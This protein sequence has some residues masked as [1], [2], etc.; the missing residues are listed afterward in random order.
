MCGLV[1]IAGDLSH[2]HEKVM[3]QLFLLDYFRGLDSTGFAAVRNGGEVHIAKGA[4]DPITLF[5]DRR[6]I[7]ALSGFNSKIFLGHNR[8]ATRGVV[9]NFN[10][11]P[12]QSGHITC[13][14]NGTLDYSSASYLEDMLGEKFNVDSQALVAAIAAFGVQE[15][16][17]SVSGA[18]SLTWYDAKEDTL[19]FLRNKERPMWFCW[20]ADF[21]LILW[22]SEW[23]MLESVARANSIELYTEAKTGHKFWPTGEDQHLVLPADFYKKAG[24]TPP[25]FKMK[26]I[27]GKERQTYTPVT[28]NYGAGA[29]GSSNKHDPFLRN[30]TTSGNASGSGT[31]KATT[32]TVGRPSS[33]SP[34]VVTLLGEIGNSFG[35]MV[36]V[37]DF[38]NL[39][40]NGCSWCEGPV[41]FNETGVVIIETQ[42]VILCPNCSG[43][44]RQQ[45]KLFV[46]EMPNQ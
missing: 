9:N 44:D 32:T 23:W 34:K 12:F 21:K 30:S 43:E 26:V 33:A 4:C 13:A 5:H 3:K 25:K 14:H 19:N 16:I 2:T 31:S 8:A 42:G 38:E 41:A 37:K 18:W 35:G 39:A 27:K 11:H 46:R 1:G 24:K 15:T 36:T 29:G 17:S 10:A 22:A 6:F 7:T 40:R 28:G 20:S 45:N